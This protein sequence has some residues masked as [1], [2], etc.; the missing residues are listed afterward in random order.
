MAAYRFFSRLPH[1]LSTDRINK[2]QDDQFVGQQLQGPMASSLGRIAACQV[3]SLLLN[4]PLDFDFIRARGLGL[5]I[6]GG[7]DT[8]RHK[9]STNPSHTPEARA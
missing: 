2:P 4:I 1:R 6:N 7:V 3:H 5:R 9:P 8:F